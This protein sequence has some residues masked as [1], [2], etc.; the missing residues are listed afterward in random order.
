MTG[1]VLPQLGNY[2]LGLTLLTSICKVQFRL[3][4]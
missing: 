3:E 2:D 1:F 4:N